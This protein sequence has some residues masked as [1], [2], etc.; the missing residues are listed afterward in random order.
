MDHGLWRRQAAW[1]K[2]SEGNLLSIVEFAG[3]SPFATRRRA[4][5]S[6][7]G[8]T[9]DRSTLVGSLVCKRA[10]IVFSHELTVR[11]WLSRE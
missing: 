8:V 4:V 1:F 5:F 10:S 9:S 2:D 6:R 11:S 7:G 3:G